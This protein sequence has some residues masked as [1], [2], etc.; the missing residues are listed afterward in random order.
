M[1]K[2]VKITL[3]GICTLVALVAVIVFLVLPNA[4]AS[5]EQELHELEQT[6][7][8]SLMNIDVPEAPEVPEVAN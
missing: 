1:K 7:V 8:D 3:W 5:S 4:F 2:S 6:N